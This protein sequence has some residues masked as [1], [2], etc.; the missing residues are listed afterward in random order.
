M[1]NPSYHRTE[2]LVVTERMRRQIAGTVAELDLAQIAISRHLTPAQRTFPALSM[3]AASQRVA[4][5]HLRARRPELDNNEA[6][7]I[8]RTMG[9]VEYERSKRQQEPQL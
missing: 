1:Q 2:P 7:R 3:I 8:V 6:L 9:I 5:Y 4:A